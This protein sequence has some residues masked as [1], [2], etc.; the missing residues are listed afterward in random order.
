MQGWYPDPSGAS[1]RFRYWDGSRWS[2]QTTADPAHTPPPT[3]RRARR[4]GPLVALITLAVVITVVVAL[5]V[6]AFLSTDSPTV[7]PGPLPSSSVSGWDDSS[8]TASPLPTPTP[9]PPPT[10]SPEPTPSATDDVQPCPEG[11]PFERTVH[12]NDGRIHGGGLSFAPVSGWSR[13]MFSGISW[14]YDVDSQGIAT[15]P[16]WM[17]GFAVGALFT[18]DGFDQPKRAAELSMDCLVTSGYYSHFS[19]RKDVSARRVTV[20]GRQGWAIRSEIQVDDPQVEAAGDVVDVV[21]VDTGSPEALSMFI[22]TV[23][24]GDEKLI[25]ILDDRVA[26]LAVD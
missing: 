10:P 9:T 3:D 14:A 18:G 12:P 17:A 25:K 4:T 24:I 21:V 5:V 15:E 1:N 13:G 23:P 16:R 7:D 26:D 22:G 20:D 11:Q 19:G 8:P 2:E 6:R